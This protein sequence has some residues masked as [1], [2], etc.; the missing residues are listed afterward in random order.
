M[1]ILR[2]AQQQFPVPH[3]RDALDRDGV[4]ADI[5][6]IVKILLDMAA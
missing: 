3:Y 5:N 4:A 1:G 2:A 6:A